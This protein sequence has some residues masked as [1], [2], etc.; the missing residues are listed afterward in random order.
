MKLISRN[1]TKQSQSYTDQWDH[2]NAVLPYSE[3]EQTYRP[4]F[5]YT[6]SIVKSIDN[7]FEEVVTLRDVGKSISQS[8]TSLPLFDDKQIISAACP[9]FN[10]NHL[11]HIR[12][13]IHNE[14]GI[15]YQGESWTAEYLFL[16]CQHSSELSQCG[17]AHVLVSE[18]VSAISS[19]RK[20]LN[21][22]L[23]ELSERSTSSRRRKQIIR[24]FSMTKVTLDLYSLASWIAM[25]YISRRLVGDSHYTFPNM[26]ES[27]LLQAVKR[28][29][30]V[31]STFSTSSNTDRALKAL[32]QY[33]ASKQVKAVMKS[34]VIELTES[35]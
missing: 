17:A 2:L 27:T 8:S 32:S 13:Q 22:C 19:Q 31:V 4:L 12:K 5:S 23:N 9:S 10:V 6:S 33:M 28:S 35:K 21:R 34:G 30:M 20:E 16:E 25:L 29:K 26:T 3:K 14:L 1:R 15:N 7:L 11:W 24:T 18:I